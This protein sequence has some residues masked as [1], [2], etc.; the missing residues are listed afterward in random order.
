MKKLE[1][2]AKELQ[3]EYDKWCDIYHD[4]VREEFKIFANG[5]LEGIYWS[6]FKVKDTLEEILNEQK[7]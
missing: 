3:K 4:S 6:L 7:G 1:K 5:Y 2:L